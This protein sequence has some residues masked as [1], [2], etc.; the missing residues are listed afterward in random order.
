MWFVVRDAVIHEMGWFGKILQREELRQ[1]PFRRQT[2]SEGRRQL[3]PVILGTRGMFP[4]IVAIMYY[5]SGGCS[6]FASEDTKA[7]RWEQARRK[8]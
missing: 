3:T 1:V 4:G 8:V 2:A 5:S 7:R 6:S